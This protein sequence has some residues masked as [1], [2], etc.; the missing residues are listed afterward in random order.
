MTAA[1]IKK[2][3]KRGM[4]QIS[5]YVYAEVLSLRHPWETHSRPCRHKTLTLDPNPTPQ[6]DPRLTDYHGEA[7]GVMGG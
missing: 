3:Q 7:D 4:M 6:C 1:R 2:D 5:V